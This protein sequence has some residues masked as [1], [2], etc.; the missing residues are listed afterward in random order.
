M[1]CVYGG[2]NPQR[3][4]N[5]RTNHPPSLA[6]P[7]PAAAPVP[8]LW[9]MKAFV[10]P[11]LV[12][13]LCLLPLPALAQEPVVD[14]GACNPAPRLWGSAGYVLMWISGAPLPPLVTTGPLG[15]VGPGDRPG[16]LGLP[17]TQVLIGGE[18]L[19]FGPHSGG[20]F[21]V[22][23]WLVNGL[24]VEGS[25]FFLG[26]RSSGRSL[27]APGTVGS[28]PL[29]IP[30]FN[31]ALGQESST[32][33]SLPAPQP[34]GVF[35]FQGGAALNVASK[36][37]G[38]E[39]NAVQPL[40]GRWQLLAGLRYLAFDEDL[41]LDTFSTSLTPPFDIFRTFDRFRC[42]NDFYGG[43]LG[44]RGRWEG[45]RCYLEGAAKVALGVIHQATTIDGALATN[46][47]NPVFGVGPPA[48]FAGGYLTLPTN[49][50]RFNE[51]R[52]A[53]LPELS[54]RSGCRLTERLSASIGYS[55]LYLSCV[56]R[57]G[58]Q[59]D[60]VINPTQGV[61]YTGDPSQ[62]LSGPA[63]PV[64]L[65]RRSD[66]WVQGLSFAFELRY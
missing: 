54:I 20:Q 14:G 41:R 39:L 26:E 28:A 18:D 30:Y 27:A 64:F 33:I 44:L 47:F 55:V 58:D 22:G 3:L 29:S 56:A 45:C 32:G 10:R 59:I 37:W 36:L 57:P 66:L 31:A 21:T 6:T 38:A 34:A 62:A 65:D 1:T 46:D 53:V 52:F 19:G 7:H 48:T 5:L 16:T 23:S 24:G 51:D 60:H 2:C 25:F 40:A 13:L 42:S 63:R 12:G 50:G 35:P 15:V 61:A 49:I 11:L 43:Q 8:M 9:S 4:P 17:G